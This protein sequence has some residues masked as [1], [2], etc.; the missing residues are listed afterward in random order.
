MPE[1][2][3]REC[4]PNDSVREI[5][6]CIYQTDPYIYPYACAEDLHLWTRIVEQ[7]LPDPNNIFYRGNLSV[8]EVDGSIAGIVCTIKGGQNYVFSKGLS[9]P[10]TL[11]DNIRSVEKGYFQ[12]LFEDNRKLT[13]FNITNVCVL[14]THRRRGIADRLMS[15]CIERY[16][17]DLHLEVI[18]DNQAAVSLYEKHGFVKVTNC[19]GYTPDGGDLPCLLYLRQQ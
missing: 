2:I 16:Q 11:K 3:C 17:D 15:F 6:L 18:A 1:I 14:S 8:A 9:V 19:N 13:G 4:L 5:A 10:E 12:P 7:C